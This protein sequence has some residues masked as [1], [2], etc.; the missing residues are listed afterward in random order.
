M[1]E[2]IKDFLTRVN[3]SEYDTIRVEGSDMLPRY[4]TSQEIIKEF[5]DMYVSSFDFNT[6][7][8]TATANA[9]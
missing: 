1:R 8:L 3:P 5:G 9:F 4:G 2:T 7:T 6:L